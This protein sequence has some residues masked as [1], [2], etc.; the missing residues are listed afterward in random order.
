MYPGQFDQAI[1]QGIMMEQVL[2]D[3]VN[4]REKADASLGPGV[5]RIIVPATIDTVPSLI[6]AHRLRTCGLL[7]TRAD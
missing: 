7:N 4:S 6:R 1:Q 5:G 3:T 2:T